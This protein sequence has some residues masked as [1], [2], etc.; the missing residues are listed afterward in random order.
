MI[1]MVVNGL[2]KELASDPAQLRSI[3]SEIVEKKCD[4]SRAFRHLV[5]QLSLPENSSLF[6]KF[7]RA[8]L[9]LYNISQAIDN[10]LSILTAS[11]QPASTQPAAAQPAAA[12]VNGAPQNDGD[13]A[14]LRE[15]IM[16]ATEE[17][18]LCKNIPVYVDAL[19]HTSE[20]VDSVK[21]EPLRI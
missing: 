9:N 8:I 1:G 20:M 18:Q 21:R 12:L 19:E 5:A 15:S 14:G 7:H 13:L 2:E 17:K 16:K 3:L 6:E 10:K 4:A 11:N